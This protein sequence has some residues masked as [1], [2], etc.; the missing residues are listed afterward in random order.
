M[1][2]V[3]PPSG[4]VETLSFASSSS[5]SLSTVEAAPMELS[6]LSSLSSSSGSLSSS[7]SSSSS[8]GGGS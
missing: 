3:P 5:L 6:S 2:K 4:F 1:E 7:L 8:G